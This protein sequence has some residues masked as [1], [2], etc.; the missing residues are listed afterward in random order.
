MMTSSNEILEF[1]KTYS[2]ELRSKA[3]YKKYLFSNFITAIK[4]INEVAKIAEKYNHHPKLINSYSSVEL[5][6]ITNDVG[7]ITQIDINMAKKCEF[8]YLNYNCK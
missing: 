4:F 6:W 1:L 8:L 3:L 2:W 5:Y 7:E